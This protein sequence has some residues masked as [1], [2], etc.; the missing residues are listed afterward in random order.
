MCRCCVGGVGV[1]RVPHNSHTRRRHPRPLAPRQAP[2]L[3]ILAVLLAHLSSP[4]GV[5]GDHASLR[6]CR[7]RV[8]RYLITTYGEKTAP[9]GRE[10]SERLFSKRGTWEKSMSPSL[11]LLPCNDLR[12]KGDI[13]RIS[14]LPRKG[15]R[16]QFWHSFGTRTLYKRLKT[17]PPCPP[18][19]RKLLWSMTLVWGD[20]RGT[21]G[22]HALFMPP[23]PPRV[24]RFPRASRAVR[25]PPAS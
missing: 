2:H 17:C 10:T 4:V 24:Y 14:S 15:G 8:N 19:C 20:M 1:A 13:K 23:C 22:G 5:A 6:M 3:V 18:F 25:A 16:T 12:Q 9:K 7:I 21:W 11:K